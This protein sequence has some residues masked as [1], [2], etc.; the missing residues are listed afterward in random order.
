MIKIKDIR[1]REAKAKSEF[2]EL[3]QSTVA[4]YSDLEG[5]STQKNKQFTMKSSLI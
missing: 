1:I 2:E 5:F 4:V 3:G